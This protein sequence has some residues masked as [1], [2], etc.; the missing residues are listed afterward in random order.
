V[1]DVANLPI[2]LFFNGDLLI[3]RSYV[4]RIWSIDYDQT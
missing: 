2:V 3:S 1:S 4:T